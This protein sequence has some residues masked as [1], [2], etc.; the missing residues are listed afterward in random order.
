MTRRTARRASPWRTST[1]AVTVLDAL[2]EADEPVAPAEA[3]GLGLAVTMGAHR[4]LVAARAGRSAE[5]SGDLVDEV[6]LVLAWDRD[7]DRGAA[8]RALGR[9]LGLGDT[10]AVD[11][12]PD[13]VDGLVSA[14]VTVPPGACGISVT[15]VPPRRS[16][17][18]LGVWC[19]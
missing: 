8:A 13:D 3:D 10:R 17:P 18:S 15:L 6:A 12:L 11:S 5:R 19:R 14:V 9:H 7:D 16:R 1:G 4:G 2:G